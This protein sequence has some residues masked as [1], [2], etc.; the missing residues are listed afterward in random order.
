[1]SIFPFLDNI[2]TNNIGNDAKWKI[3]GDVID[4]A[5][6][7]GINQT[8]TKT[9]LRDYGFSFGNSA[10]SQAYNDLLSFRVSF[11]YPTTLDDDIKPNYDLIQTS[12][13]VPSGIY[14]YKGSVLVF[15]SE[16]DTLREKFFTINTTDILS[17]SQAIDYLWEYGLPQS[18]LTGEIAGDIIY[19]G[20]LRG[21]GQ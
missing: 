4:Y 16:N 7:E 18:P 10:F 21:I 1:M 8:D 5:I 19:E 17:K 9:L 14:Q 3:I 12:I 20:M 6:S 15:D 13:R 11:E 2:D